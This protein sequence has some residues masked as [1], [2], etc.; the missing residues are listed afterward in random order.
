MKTN[1]IDAAKYQGYYWMSNETS[2]TLLDNGKEFYN[3]LNPASN[4]FIIEA[5]LYDEE[6]MVSY[7]IKYVDGRY[8]VNKWENVSKDCANEN[9]YTLISYY[10]NR[11]EDEKG[12][13]IEKLYFLQH[14]VEVN[15]PACAGD[16]DDEDSGMTVL[17]PKEL[18]FVGF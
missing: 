11:L 6:K 5:L 1:K 7:S 17:Q 4:P 2:P 14:W 18:I 10:S 13:K 3:E 8:I 15:D 9:D 16:M 12:N